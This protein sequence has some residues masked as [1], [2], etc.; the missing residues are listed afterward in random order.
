MNTERITRPK[1]ARFTRTTHHKPAPMGSRRKA[2]TRA[3]AQAERAG[4]TL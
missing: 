1:V 4:V 2:M 3:T